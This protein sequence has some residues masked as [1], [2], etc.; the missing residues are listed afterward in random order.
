MSVNCTGITCS[1]GRRLQIDTSDPDNLTVELVRDYRS[2]QGLKSAIMGSMQPIMD[3]LKAKTSDLGYVLLGWGDNAEFSEYTSDGSL[4]RDVQFSPLDPRHTSGGGIGWSSYRTFKQ[5]WHGYPT[6][7][8]SIATD[9]NG[10]LWVSW[11]GATEVHEWALYGA[12]SEASL[13]EAHGSSNVTNGIS[14][15]SNLVEIMEREGFETEI[16]M[17][18]HTPEFVKVVALDD[19]GNAIGS[20]DTIETGFTPS[21]TSQ[22]GCLFQDSLS[23]ICLVRLLV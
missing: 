16:L 19:N 21:L 17:T 13:G 9:S 15:R 23:L 10:T 22:P 20:T 4:V 18:T 1:R 11:N 6:W 8:P 7:A 14:K 12:E 2:P 3:P 5:S